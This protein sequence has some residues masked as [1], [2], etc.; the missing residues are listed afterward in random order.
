M[1]ALTMAGVCASYGDRVVLSGIDISLE[2]GRICGLVGPN[3]V[4]K[5]TFL[6]AI[7][8]LGVGT[9]G[10]VLVC[11]RDFRD[12]TRN[13]LAKLVSYL[14]QNFDHRLRLT[15]HEMVLMGRHPYRKG[16]A[17]DSGED[18]KISG[19]CMK[20]IGVWHL[21]N[22]LFVEL[23]GGEKRLVM[24]AAAIA[25]EPEL[26]LL[27]EPGSSLDFKHLLEMWKLLERL[28][29]RG[30]A[31]LVSTHEITVAGRYMD[32]VLA[33]AGGRVLASGPPTGVFTPETLS[34]VFGVRLK[35]W[36]EEE[37]GSWLVVP[38]D[39]NG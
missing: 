12:L 33:L 15:V 23:S 17:P 34:E 29:G 37:T 21:R 25:Q 16:W 4:G 9:T 22:R 8:G 18:L 28:S 31:I 10:K 11:G 2:P 24:L 13:E 14:P 1:P 39:G 32:L 20:E 26:L 36:R 35:V 27:D 30:I 7:L 19:E 5:S 6:K 3:G 38:G